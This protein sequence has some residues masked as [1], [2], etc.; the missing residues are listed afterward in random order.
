MAA[1]A[2]HSR[3]RCEALLAEL[4]ALF[5]LNEARAVLE[6]VTDERKAKRMRARARGNAPALPDDYQAR[7]VVELLAAGGVLDRLVTEARA[8]RLGPLLAPND[9]RDRWQRIVDAWNRAIE[10]NDW[11][12]LPPLCEV[13][14]LP[15]L[16][17]GGD[18]RGRTVELSV[19]C[20]QKC[21]NARKV[22]RWR[23]GR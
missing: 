14:G 16:L 21:S 8:L 6:R 7:H 4:L 11:V 19:T 13:C 3:A 23:K 10:R 2:S 12:T 22:R 18:R 15:V 5:R 1:A 20:S 9:Y 17:R